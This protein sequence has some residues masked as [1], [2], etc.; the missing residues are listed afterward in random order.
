[1]RVE[2]NMRLAFKQAELA[3]ERREV[4]VGCVIVKPASENTKDED[5]VVAVGGN[6]TNQYCN[7]TKH[8]EIV[9]IDSIVD[10]YGNKNEK[11][12]KV[13]SQCELYV[14]CEPCIMCAEALNIVGIKAVYFGC[15]NERFGGCG[16]VETV[17]VNYE[18]K[19]GIFEQEGIE[20]F[21]RF[22]ARKNPCAPE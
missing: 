13:L 21:Q 7:A 2:K 4:P 11:A 9:A 6:E 5:K 10:K 17:N 12:K 14:T 3:L 16:T 20:L 1:M 19:G 15:W 22:Y 18:C 8:A